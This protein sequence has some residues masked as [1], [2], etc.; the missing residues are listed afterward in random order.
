MIDLRGSVVDIKSLKQEDIQIMYNLM[1]TFY[2]NMT[3]ENFLHD[4]YKKDFTIILK[5]EQEV[6]RG[7]S[8]QQIMHIPTAQGVVHGVFSGDTIIHKDFWGSSELFR[9][10][11]RFFLE[12]EKQYP[13][14]Y[15]F[16]ICKGYKTYKIL[17]TFFES[18]YPCYKEETPPDIKNIIDAFGKF[19]SPEEYDEK[20]GVLHY[21]GLK[22]KLKEN[23][24]D[25][26][27]GRLKDK[28]VAFFVERNPGYINGNDMVCITRI[29]KANISERKLKYLLD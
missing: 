2:D 23:I 14:F 16:L 24:A 9:V 20:S 7:F 13:L 26:N 27:E 25:V 22:D 15:W 6:I 18:F 3:M 4:L 21:K 29:S 10:F 11:I 19:Y 17:P 8:T 28:N 12:Y 1:D 5:D